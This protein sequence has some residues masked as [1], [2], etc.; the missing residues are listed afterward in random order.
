MISR[1]WHGWTKGEDADE[2]EGMLKAEV[3]PGIHRIKG[4][5]GA[6][7]LRRQVGADV[8]FCTITMF[9]DLAAVRAFAGE[10]Y[11]KAVIHGPA[12]RLLIKFDERSK[13]YEQILD[14]E[15]IRLTA[16]RM[17]ATAAR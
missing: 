4:F 15:D 11:E 14:P 6:Y 1:I 16:A 5:R 8:E 12:R 17:E 10:D 3:L 2:Y 7:L 13:H 9:E